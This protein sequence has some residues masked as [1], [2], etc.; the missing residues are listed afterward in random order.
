MIPLTLLYAP[1]DRSDLVRK[2]IAGPADV[3]IIDL[4]DAVAPDHKSAARAALPELASDNSRP[5]RVRV[6][7]IGTPWHS[8]DV[9]AVAG[10]PDAVGLLLPKAEHPEEVASLV[11]ALPG[12]AVHLLIESAI[13]VEAAFQLA[14]AGVASIALGEADLGADLGCDEAGLAFS[15]SRVIVAAR[16]AGLPAPVMSVYPNIRDIN[17]LIAS[18][19]EGRALGFRGRSAIHPSQLGPIR[20]AFM[21]TGAE[22]AQAR[23][24]MERFTTAADEGRG[25][26]AMPDGS[27]IDLALTVRYREILELAE[28]GRETL[29]QSSEVE[30][31][32]QDG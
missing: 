19:R 32:G 27:F 28:C 17:G 31:G 24:V 5:V 26:L 9:D 18:C 21:P 4:E 1:G 20:D 6:N 8:D 10:L 2:A 23:A 25:A 15:R 7:A 14:S 12:R 13:G 30:L 22:I 16:A 29:G 3:V 11:A